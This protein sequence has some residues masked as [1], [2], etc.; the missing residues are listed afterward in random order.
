MVQKLCLSG[1]LSAIVTS[2]YDG[3]TVT[4]HTKP[5][6]IQAP[7]LVCEAKIRVSNIDTPELRCPKNTP[8][9]LRLLGKRAK[10]RVQELVESKKV[11][12]ICEGRGKYGRELAN[13]ILEDGRALDCIMIE[14]FLAYPYKGKKKHDVLQQMALAEKYY[15]STKEYEL[16]KQTRLESEK[17]ANGKNKKKRKRSS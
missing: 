11:T 16:V 5:F 12:L 2:V 17:Y 6:P 15:N 4:V 1:S 9:M 14:E 3:D 13:I 8:S 7:E 10:K